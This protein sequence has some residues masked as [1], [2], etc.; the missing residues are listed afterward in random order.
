M[1]GG[2]GEGLRHRKTKSDGGGKMGLFVPGAA[3]RYCTSNGGLGVGGKREEEDILTGGGEGL[4]CSCDC[5][6]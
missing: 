6:G 1:G 4:G 5:C 2:V 3:A